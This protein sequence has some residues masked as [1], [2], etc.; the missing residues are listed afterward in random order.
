VSGGAER[1][2]AAEA[3]KGAWSFHVFLAA[4]PRVTL[5]FGRKSEF[6]PSFPPLTPQKY[7]FLSFP[8]LFETKSWFSEGKRGEMR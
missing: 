6:H 2:A 8:T 5:N 4:F 3:A 1:R 7:S